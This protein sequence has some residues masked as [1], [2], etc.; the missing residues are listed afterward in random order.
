MPPDPRRTGEEVSHA[1]PGD[2]GR[3]N[4]K[5]N[6]AAQNPSLLNFRRKACPRNVLRLAL[7]GVWHW[8]L[9]HQWND[10]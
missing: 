2:S 9:V 4:R 5:F 7:V 6:N 8:W 10:R 3:Q 1:V